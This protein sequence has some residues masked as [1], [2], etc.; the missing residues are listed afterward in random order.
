MLEHLDDD[1]AALRSMGAAVEEGGAV[2]VLVPAFGWAL[3][4]FER[5]IGHR[6]RYLLRDV[7]ALAEAAGLQVQQA[8]YFNSLGLLAW[9]I[10]VTVLRLTPKPGPMLTAWDRAAVPVLRVLET[11]RPPPFGREIFLVARRP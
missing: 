11:R 2:L 5:G 9:D 4:G 8:S 10:G 6:R 3:S 1:A 7:V